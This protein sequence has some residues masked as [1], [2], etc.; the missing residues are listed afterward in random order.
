MPPMSPFD[1]LNF[2]LRLTA[3]IVDTQTVMALRIWG[4]S[5]ALPQRPGENLRMVQEKGPAM[6]KAFAAGS[7]ALMAGKRPDQVVDAALA[8]LSRKV[9]S[10]RKRLLR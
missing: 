7:T 5:G 4:M 8:P 1:L 3:L 10:N 2:N 9:R 6:L